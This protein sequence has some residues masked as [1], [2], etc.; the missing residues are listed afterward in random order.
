MVGELRDHP[1]MRQ[2]RQSAATYRAG[3]EDLA[4]LQGHLEAIEMAL[5]GEVP[6][7]GP[8]PQARQHLEQALFQQARA[9]TRPIG[10]GQARGDVGAKGRVAAGQRQHRPGAAGA[11]RLADRWGGMQATFEAGQT[12]A[13]AAAS[14]AAQVVELAFFDQRTVVGKWLGSCGIITRRA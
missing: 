12:D 7:S 10:I 6:R 14:G 5:E 4:S 2:L 3:S 1:H 13:Q 8:S 9:R 11:E